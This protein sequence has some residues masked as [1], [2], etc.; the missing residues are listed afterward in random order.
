MIINMSE[1]SNQTSLH[2]INCCV[3]MA[4][5]IPHSNLC[6]LGVLALKFFTGVERSGHGG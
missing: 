6:P 4:C 3:Y 2:T 5:E 1:L